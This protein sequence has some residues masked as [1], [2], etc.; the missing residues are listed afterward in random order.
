MALLAGANDLGGTL[1]NEHISRAAGAQHGQE[2][3]VEGMRAL[4]ATLP[5][6]SL[7]GEQRWTWHRTTLYAPAAGER[8]DTA[9]KAPELRPI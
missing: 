3:T 5:A 2:M 8:T 6:D 7:T 1:M 9:V 4:A